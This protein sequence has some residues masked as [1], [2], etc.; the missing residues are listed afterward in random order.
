[1]KY[2]HHL[3]HGLS[4]FVINMLGLSMAMACLI[5]TILFVQ[6]EFSYDTRH[7]KADRI[8]RVTTNS[9]DGAASIH[10]A[11]VAG[12]W[13]L[14]L[15]NDYPAIEALVRLVP[16][17]KAVIKIEDQIFY[18]KNTYATDSSFFKVFDFKIIS[19]NPLTSLSKPG[20]VLICKSMAMKYF[21]S[22][23]VTGKEI[24]IRYQQDPHPN[25]FIIDGVMEDFPRNSHF[26]IDLLTSFTSTEERTTWAYTYFLMKKGTDV[27]ALRKTIQGKWNKENRDKAV[28]SILYL[29][30]L[31]NIHLFS[32]KERE[33]ETNGDIR[34]VIL[35]VSGALIIFLIALINYLNLNRVQFI[36][37]MK[38]LKI[39]MI[40]G[41]SRFRLAY[42]LIAKSLLL[43]ICSFFAGFIAA[44]EVG[45]ILGNSSV[46][47]YQ[48]KSLVGIGF[49]FIIIIALIAVM[50]LFTS[51]FSLKRK[52]LPVNRNLYAAPL[53]V[54]FM[55]SVIA[56]ICTIGLYRQMNYLNNQHPASQNAN[57]LVIANNPSESVQR[58]DAFK[59]E[60]L[61]NPSILDV[62]GALEEP[63]GEILDKCYFE[64]EGVDKKEDQGINLLTTDPNFFHFMGI[65]PVAGTTDLGFTPSQQWEADVIKLYSLRSEEKRNE[66]E[67]ASLENKQ[68]NY[69][70]KYIVN[71]SALKMLGISNPHDAIG[72]RFRLHF[73][74]PEL[75]PEGEIVGVVPDFHYTNL[76]Q[77]EK[78]LAIVPVR[79]FNYCF[80]V[81]IDPLQRSKAIT[82]LQKT[83]KKVNP[84]YPLE[85][86]YITDNYHKVYATE[87]SQSRVLSLFA[88]ISV[89]I[90]SLGIFALAAFMMQRRTKE[91]GIRKVNGAQVV[92]IMSLLNRSFIQWV[93]VAFVFACPV[94]WFALYQWL[95]H[96]AYK[97]ALSWWI[98]AMAGV[99][100]ITVALLTV[101]WQSWRTAKQNPV[102]ALRYE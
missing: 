1:M 8:Y 71:L 67:I 77:V 55:L 87:Y 63:G 31:T 48:I 39:R 80:I 57:M 93:V 60:L 102:E 37:K 84:E 3:K 94:A 54:Q 70:E 42:E 74:I 30:K 69:R 15:M 34:S 21:G 72:K 4:W 20:R 29:Q 99:T 56:I 62:T 9:N 32:H 28:A 38:S 76:Y 47:P 58:Y 33:M 13:P 16:Y 81:R 11:R 46:E 64:M 50:P 45:R 79:T 7:A 68:G 18:S 26:H 35:L 5:A 23:D 61:T 95:Q 88:L 59:G 41:A 27:E 24:T 85:Y 2:L 25:N 12:E 53:V 91:I 96:F 101:S 97:T 82:A 14:Q 100:A 66:Q 44:S 49:G 40:I 86:E 89:I 51:G 10:P 92:E 83:W 78:P 98:F 52:E 22:I 43:S 90:S 19:G 6:F 17:R 75:L 65:H 36:F 73:F